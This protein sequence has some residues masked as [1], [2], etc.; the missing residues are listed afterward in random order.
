MPVAMVNVREVSMSVCQGL[1]LVRMRMR[2]LSVP[3]EIM[4]VLVMFVMPVRM[5]M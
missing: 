4:R 2:L 1:V 5:R 3:R